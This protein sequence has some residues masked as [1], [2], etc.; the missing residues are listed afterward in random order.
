[1]L[2]K[3]GGDSTSELVERVRA[4]RAALGAHFAA[5]GSGEPPAGAG[6]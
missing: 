1:V 6:G 2:E 4:G 5:R 3:F